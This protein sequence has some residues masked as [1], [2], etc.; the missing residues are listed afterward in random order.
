MARTKPRKWIAKEIAALDPTKDYAEI[1]KLAVI[2]RSNDTFMDL[3]YSITFPNFVVPNHG[4][5]AVLRD[6]KGKVFKNTER[7]MDD[8]GRHILI[9]SEY[10]PDHPYTKKSVDALNKLHSF[11][12]KKYPG[13]FR[14]NIDYLY[15]MCYEATLFHRLMQRVGL[16]GM[17]EKEQIASWEFWRR[18]AP[19]FINA[20]TGGPITDFPDSFEGCME[21]VEAYEA[22]R[23]PPSKYADQID[24]TMI[25]AFGKRYFPKP[26]QPAARTLVM[27]LLPEGTV[28]GLGLKPA[29]PVAKAIC[30]F[31]FRCFLWM[32]DKIIPDPDVSHPEQIRQRLRLPELEYTD[33]VSTGT[34][35]M[36][37]DLKASA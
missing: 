29:S 1:W 9:W 2:Y 22:E 30:R 28:R 25:Q 10:G 23:R 24:E 5:I 36:P 16:K 20:E 11:Y 6:G 27:S 19:L 14:H 4:A 12:S 34:P 32:G 31:G 15:T 35:I 17:T 7:R 3:M 26:L 13:S 33:E 37:D 18:M 8:T 21:M